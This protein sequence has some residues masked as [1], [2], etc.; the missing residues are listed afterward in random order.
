[1]TDQT[2]ILLASC[3]AQNNNPTLSAP[4]CSRHGTPK[5]SIAGGP[6]CVSLQTPSYKNKIL[7][8]EFVSQHE[9]QSQMPRNQ[10]AISR[11]YGQGTR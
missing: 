9:T 10:I 1:M 6:T 5:P 7:H 8:D 11:A 2:C 4:P 3:P